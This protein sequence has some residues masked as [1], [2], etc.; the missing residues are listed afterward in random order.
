MW[1]LFTTFIEN[2]RYFDDNDD[3]KA[4]IGFKGIV[5]VFFIS[6]LLC[7][8]TNQECNAQATIWNVPSA[9]VLS[10]AELGFTHYSQYVKPL[11]D[12][13]AYNTVNGAMLGIGYNTEVDTTLFNVGIP[14]SGNISLGLGTKTVIPVLKKEFPEQEFKVTFGEILPV[15]LQGEGVGDWTYGHFSFKLP[16]AKTR[17]T[18]GVLYG[19]KQIFGRNVIAYMFGLEQPLTKNLSLTADWISGTH[20]AGFVTIGGVITYKGFSGGV[21]VQIPNNKLCGKIGPTL[22]LMKVFKLPF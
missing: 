6:C 17:I 18:N 4:W 19:T 8:L 21:G 13:S 2:N 10:K 5:F 7:S 11:S 3:N 9:D 20:G 14:E 1:R 12:D 15:S 22:Y 16:K